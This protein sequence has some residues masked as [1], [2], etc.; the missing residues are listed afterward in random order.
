MQTCYFMTCFMGTLEQ[1]ELLPIMVR[2]CSFMLLTCHWKAHSFY[3]VLS[4]FPSHCPLFIPSPA[5]AFLGGLP[6]CQEGGWRSRCVI[7]SRISP[8]HPASWYSHHIVAPWGFLPEYQHTTGDFLL[9]FQLACKPL[10]SCISSLSLLPFYLF[11]PHSLLCCLLFL[12]LIPAMRKEE[13]LFFWP[14]W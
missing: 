9:S 13:R 11:L 7:Q 5:S 6:A 14:L 2:V 4:L 10:C 3:L 8:S 1:T 12:F